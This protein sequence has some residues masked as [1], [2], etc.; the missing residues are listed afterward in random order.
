MSAKAEAPLSLSPCGIDKFTA[1]DG[2]PWAS[3][4]APADGASANGQLPALSANDAVALV[5]DGRKALHIGPLFADS[6]DRALVGQS[7]RRSETGPVLIDA[8][9]T[10]DAVSPHKEFLNGLTGS[11]WRIERRSSACDLAAS[12]HRC[13]KRRSHVAGPEYG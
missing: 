12:P 13:E 7:D 3:I 4:E 10:Q 11:G 1:Q 8:V 9:S 6:P 2:L 5:R